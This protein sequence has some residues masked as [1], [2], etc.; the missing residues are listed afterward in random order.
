MIRKLNDTRARN[1]K[2]TLEGKP[3]KHTDGGGLYLLVSQKG[4]YWR[5]NYQFNK[6]YKTLSLGVYPDV[7]LKDV[8]VAHEEA[9][10][11][12]KRGVDSSEY[13]KIHGQ[14]LWGLFRCL[15]NNTIEQFRTELGEVADQIISAL[16]HTINGFFMQA[17]QMDSFTLELE[18][19]QNA[20][21]LG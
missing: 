17:L 20:V 6:K 11:L 21:L 9:R 14:R 16:E 4:K 18:A 10:E 12:L 1:A 13:K 2:P 8:R 7:S 19:N 15:I 5:Y 3:K